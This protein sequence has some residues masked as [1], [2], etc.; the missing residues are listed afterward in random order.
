MLLDT[1]KMK[2]LSQI[3]EKTFEAKINEMSSKEREELKNFDELWK[4][5]KGYHV[6]V[7]HKEL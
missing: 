7:N 2:Y 6:I 1:K 3:D 4:L 5:S